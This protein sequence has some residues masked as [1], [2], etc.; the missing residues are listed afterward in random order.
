MDCLNVQDLGRVNRRGLDGAMDVIDAG[1]G[2]YRYG[3][4]KSGLI[5]S[6]TR[7]CGDSGE[8]T[9]CKTD[10]QLIHIINIIIIIM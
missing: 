10:T 9:P 3:L 5:S 6:R 7:I 2:V 1:V 8:S 4:G